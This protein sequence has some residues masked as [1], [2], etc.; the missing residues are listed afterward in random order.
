M[1]RKTAKSLKYENMRK[2]KERK[3]LESPAPEPIIDLPDLRK[4]IVITNFDFGEEVH[5]FE[6]MQT[7]RIDQYKV[8]VDG[9][10]WKH[11]IGLSGILAGVRKSMPPVRS[12]YAN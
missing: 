10:L 1:Y 8:L 4:T 11:R 12:I 5:R 9:E 6:L 2:A 3:R 7:G